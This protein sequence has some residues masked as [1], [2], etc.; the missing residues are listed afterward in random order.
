MNP[1]ELGLFVE[2]DRTGFRPG[3][4]LVLS[5]LWALPE[6][7]ASLEVRLFF[8]TRGKGT[9]DVEVVATR[10]L[11]ADAAAGEGRAEFVLPEA[12]YSFSGKLISVLWAAELIAEPGSRAT[13]CDFVLS[14]T[15]QELLLHP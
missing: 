11:S 5:V 7:P 4:T 12:P 13:R 14:P 6:K 1:E 15:G 2:N 9:E 10:T 3:E 8:Y